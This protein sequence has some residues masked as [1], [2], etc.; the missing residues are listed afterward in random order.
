MK[1]GTSSFPVVAIQTFHSM[2]VFSRYEEFHCCRTYVLTPRH[3]TVTTHTGI[4]SA[5]PLRCRL[6]M[7]LCH[8]RPSLKQIDV[9]GSSP[10]GHAGGK[11]VV[12]GRKDDTPSFEGVALLGM[13]NVR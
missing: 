4:I 9:S 13:A 12:T 7:Y 10:L 5:L 3:G 8:R 6:M 2:P 1:A 11:C